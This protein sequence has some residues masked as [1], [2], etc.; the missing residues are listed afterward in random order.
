MAEPLRPAKFEFG[1]SQIISGVGRGDPRASL[2]P[3]S[4]VPNPIPMSPP[5]DLKAD[6]FPEV[7]F[8]T[9][10]RS[11]SS[12][13]S[14][15]NGSPRPSS[16]GSPAHSEFTTY[17]THSNSSGFGASASLAVAAVAI[18]DSGIATDESSFANAQPKQ[19]ASSRRY[20]S[21]LA[22][23]RDDEELLTR[24]SG[25]PTTGTYFV[26]L[27]LLFLF[28]LAHCAFVFL[29]VSLFFPSLLV[30]FNRILTLSLMSMTSVF[31]LCVP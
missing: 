7:D 28:C 13:T 6:T 23:Q 3:T 27:V 11:S 15:P 4:T 2:P 16:R 1:P 20:R 29:F 17:S 9:A 18:N 24:P 19:E 25:I 22:R 21:L 30:R 5:A 31:E 8:K 12:G 10:I 14:L 26:V